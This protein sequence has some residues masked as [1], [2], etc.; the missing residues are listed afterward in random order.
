MAE[1][2]TTET[3]STELAARPIYT[4]LARI[5]KALSNP[6]RLRLLDLLEG[7]E[8]TVEELSRDSGIPIKNTSAQLQQL[9]A[10]YL[11][12]S[13]KDGNRVYYRIADEQVSRFL[14]V[15]GGFAADRLADLRDAV[16][17]YLGELTTLE[18]V[19]VDE[20][21]TRLGSGA[22]VVDV[23]PESDYANGHIPEAISVPSES[24]LSRL[25]DL[26]PDTDIVAYC[27]GPYCVAS[28]KF[29]RTLREHG[30]TAHHLAGGLTGW[31]RT[32]HP[33][34]TTTGAGG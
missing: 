7:R 22:L 10:A 11:V 28:A 6:L 33:L 20:L 24:L 16:S 14:G 4:E 3:T 25:S 23:R 1:L 17:D 21:S 12:K 29:V 32:G 26:P 19:T 15:L 34:D 8:R 30:R 9:R 13:R 31:H 2:T 27:H 18:P 5:G